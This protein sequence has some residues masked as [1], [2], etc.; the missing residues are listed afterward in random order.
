MNK[1]LTITNKN[2]KNIIVKLQKQSIKVV[3]SKT[4]NRRQLTEKSTVDSKI[5]TKTV[6]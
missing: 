5:P 2:R 1:V 3:Y 4:N 6:H